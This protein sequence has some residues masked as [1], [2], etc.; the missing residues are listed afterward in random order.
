MIDYARRH[1][2]PV[3]S[4]LRLYERILRDFG[5]TFTSNTARL[6]YASGMQWLALSILPIG[7][8]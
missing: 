6:G 1:D 4:N 2:N 3:E 5:P 7:W 8:E